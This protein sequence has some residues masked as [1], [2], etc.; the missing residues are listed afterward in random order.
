MFV[1]PFHKHPHLPISDI[2][3]WTERGFRDIK[4][5]YVFKSRC[6]PHY[7]RER[8]APCPTTEENPVWQAQPALTRHQ[9]PTEQRAF[10]SAPNTEKL[11]S[12]NPA[13]RHINTETMINSSTLCWTSCLKILF[14][15]SAFITAWCSPLFCEHLPFHLHFIQVY[16][17]AEVNPPFFVIHQFSSNKETELFGVYSL[18]F[19]V[20]LSLTPCL[21]PPISEIPRVLSHPD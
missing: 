15:A 19:A 3:D 9:E 14:T 13:M 8:L 21:V 4:D 7:R 1:C 20:R 5:F 17:T 10:I 2:C 6:L 11:K 18:M 16:Q 12:E